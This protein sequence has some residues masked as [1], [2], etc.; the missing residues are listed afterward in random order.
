MS[1]RAR[2]FLLSALQWYS[3]KNEIVRTQRIYSDLVVHSRA[4]HRWLPTVFALLASRTIMTVVNPCHLCLLS[5]QPMVQRMHHHSF[6]VDD[7]A[8]T[9]KYW[10]H[11]TFEVGECFPH[12]RCRHLRSLLSLT[13]L[14]HV[15]HCIVAVSSAL[16]SSVCIVNHYRYRIHVGTS[17]R[18]S[19]NNAY[20][21][22]LFAIHVGTL[23][24]AHG[25]VCIY[26]A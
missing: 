20:Q 24:G 11:H 23:R 18:G 17:H 14:S 22:L 25:T 7:I 2:L 12:L 9:C 8:T 5:S 21:S 10:R 19:W 16:Y 6:N 1:I 4:V 15:S 3:L 13:L 26:H